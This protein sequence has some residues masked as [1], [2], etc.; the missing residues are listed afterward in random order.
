MICRGAPLDNVWDIKEGVWLFSD[1]SGNHLNRLR[2]DQVPSLDLVDVD[3][4]PKMNDRIFKFSPSYCFFFK[5]C[6]QKMKQKK[7]MTNQFQRPELEFNL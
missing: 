1:I 6:L 7:N 3:I 4:D 5:L 2:R